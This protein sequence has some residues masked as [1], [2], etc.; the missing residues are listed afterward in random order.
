MNL[1]SLLP[2]WPDGASFLQMG[3]HGAYVW[4]A[5]AATALALAAE[6]WTLRRRAQRLRA[7]TA[8]PE[9]QAT[10]TAPA[11]PTAEPFA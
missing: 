8:T 5:L 6:W 10:P 2:W 3:R 7:S 1:Q 4:P 9:P 11:T